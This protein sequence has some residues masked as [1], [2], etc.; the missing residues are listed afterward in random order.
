MYK[1]ITTNSTFTVPKDTIILSF[2]G[3]KTPEALIQAR[4]VLRKMASSIANDIALILDGNIIATIKHRFVGRF[5][6]YTIV[7]AV[8]EAWQH[9]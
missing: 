9:V 8:K 1:I 5:Y 6:G 3:D 2:T 4:K 7:T